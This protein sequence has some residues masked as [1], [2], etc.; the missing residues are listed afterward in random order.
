MMIMF[1]L[2]YTWRQAQIYY[3]NHWIAEYNYVFFDPHEHDWAKV[4]KSPDKGANINKEK[5]TQKDPTKKFGSTKRP[6]EDTK[7]KQNKN[8]FPTTQES[9]EESIPDID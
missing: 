1:K 4:E 7:D 5:E 2:F 8:I 6:K 9:D 3:E